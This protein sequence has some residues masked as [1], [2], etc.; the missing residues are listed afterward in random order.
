MQLERLDPDDVRD[1]TSVAF[2]PDGEFIVSG[3]AAGKVALCTVAS[4][5]R[6]FLP[7]PRSDAFSR[8]NTV[9]YAKNGWIAAGREDGTIT[10][11]DRRGDSGEP[12]VFTLP[13]PARSESGNPNG[14][15]NAVASLSF[16]PNG[17]MLA[18]GY[19]S[20]MI[21]LWDVGQQR[22]IGSLNQDG[23]ALNSLDFSPDGGLIAAADKTGGVVLWN[24]LGQARVG[25]L[26]LSH[27]PSASSV[28]F[29]PDAAF[30]A[31]GS[32]A[33][34]IYLWNLREPPPGVATLVDVGLDPVTV[35]AFAPATAQLAVGNDS[36]DVR[37][38]AR[39]DGEERYRC[40][41]LDA[42]FDS[43]LRLALSHNGDLLAVG[44]KQGSIVVYRLDGNQ[45][46][47]SFSL[48]PTAESLES[49]TFSRDDRWLIAGVAA[50][51]V[52]Q[53]ADTKTG[54]I[55][56]WDLE[57]GQKMQTNRE[58][59]VTALV[60]GPVQFELASYDAE[61]TIW[62]IDSGSLVN[63]RALSTPVPTPVQG[64]VATAA[65][66]PTP[67]PVRSLSFD[68]EGKKLAA[69]G[70]IGGAVWDT[71]TNALILAPGTQMRAT[72]GIV[73]SPEGRMLASATTY[74][75]LYLWDTERVESAA[76]SLGTLPAAIVGLGW[77]EFD[78]LLVSDKMGMLVEVDLDAD[79]WITRACQT[80]REFAPEDTEQLAAEDC[81]NTSGNVSASP[82]AGG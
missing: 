45:R 12:A 16:N 20:G 30:L 71:L 70:G 46:L 42:G 28:T 25:P 50:H 54:A 1:V 34:T 51:S 8:V 63:P 10:L 2:S 4:R 77:D 13:V 69:A 27:V 24:V 48:D 57:T 67:G 32:G 66:L 81:P 33:G 60:D 52:E 7:N 35:A 53:D 74:G 55:M 79:A 21:W 11:W 75:A 59:P 23:V 56:L 19:S 31:S 36:G 29:S 58:A 62:M 15:G 72:Q 65:G 18:G 64:V 49:L 78:S 76:V 9:A 82:I 22:E 73:F 37:T 44:D 39:V 61:A 80:A 6:E 14:L 40:A 68:P 3:D 41:Q 17:S 47:T 5:A 43:V 38:C 26:A